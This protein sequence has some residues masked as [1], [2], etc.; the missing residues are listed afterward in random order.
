MPH[1]DQFST[2]KF[3]VPAQLFSWG[4]LARLSFSTVCLKAVLLTL[5]SLLIF[6]Y[7]EIAK[8]IV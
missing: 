4:Q 2:S 3:L 8:V 6:S 5:F 1:F 7:R